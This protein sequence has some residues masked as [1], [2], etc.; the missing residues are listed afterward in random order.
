MR[1]VIGMALVWGGYAVGLYAYCL[2]AGY[3]V[4]FGSLVNPSARWVG[5]NGLT[6][7]DTGSYSWPPGQAS[8]TEILPSAKGSAGPITVG[9]DGSVG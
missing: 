6:K 9:S 4:T 5:H 3:G 7:S 2:L 1:P 8:N